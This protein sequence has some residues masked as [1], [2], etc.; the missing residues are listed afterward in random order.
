MPQKAGNEECQGH[1]DEEW[2]SG[3]PGRLP[4]LR[5]QDVQDREVILLLARNERGW[6]YPASFQFK[7]VWKNM[8]FYL[9]V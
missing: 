3:H 8:I 5:H 6:I 9:G 7:D 2:S 4:R 1:Y